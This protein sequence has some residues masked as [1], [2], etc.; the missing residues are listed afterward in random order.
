MLSSAPTSPRACSTDKTPK[1]E[2]RVAP[3]RGGEPGVGGDLTRDVALAE[4]GGGRKGD[5]EEACSSS[6]QVTDLS[7]QGIPQK[8]QKIPFLLLGPWGAGRLL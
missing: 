5:K 2:G 3:H 7:L 8:G 6:L 4:K 1:C